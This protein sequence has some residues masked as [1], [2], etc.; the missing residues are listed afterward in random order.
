MTG[1]PPDEKAR[2]F[3]S[4]GMSPEVAGAGA[5]GADETMGRCIPSLHRSA[6]QPVMAQLGERL[7]G[8]VARPGLVI[9]A[10]EDHYT[11]GEDRARWMAE[12]AGAKVAVLKGLGHWWMCQDP[13]AGAKALE[14]FW[15]GL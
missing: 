11:G 5:A 8:A 15:A 4:L 3:E 2:L 1:L 12:R 6:A 14:D 13:A 9:I 10:T 7:P